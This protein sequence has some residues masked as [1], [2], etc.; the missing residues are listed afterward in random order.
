[1]QPFA[2]GWWEQQMPIGF[3]PNTMRSDGKPY[4][5]GG[6]FLDVDPPRKLVQTWRYDWGDRHET[7]LT[8][9]LEPAAGGTGGTHLT[10]R[11]EGF[12]SHSEAC[13]AHSDG[14]TMVLGWLAGYLA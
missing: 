13:Q 7:T 6:E 1:M 9:R 5:V 12:G 3:C 14:W 11:H 8:Y 4:S 10:V 2:V